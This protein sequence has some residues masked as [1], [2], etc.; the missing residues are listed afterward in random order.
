MLHPARH[1]TIPVQD[2]KLEIF[3]AVDPE[4]CPMALVM[5]LLNKSLLCGNVF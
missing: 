4:L 1:G 5:S 3:Q 2:V